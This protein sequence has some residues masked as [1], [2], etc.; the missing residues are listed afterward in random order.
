MRRKFIIFVLVPVLAAFIVTYLFIDR[1]VEHGLESMGERIV[2]AKVEIDNVTLSLSP[3]A[4]QFSRLQVAN[5]RDP[6]SNIFETGRVRF[7]L[8]M[9][10]LLRTKFIVETIEVNDLVLGT[11]RISDGSLGVQKQ[12]QAISSSAG[13]AVETPSLTSEAET[14]R[15]S[16]ELKPPVLDLVR[17]KRELNLDSLLH[18]RNFQTFRLLDSLKSG[19]A[20]S[21]AAWEKSKLE[22][23]NSKR[24]LADAETRIKTIQMNEIKSVDA[25]R[26]ALDKIITAER[27]IDDASKILQNQ[28]AVLADMLGRLSASVQRVDDVAKGDFQNLLRFAQVPDANMKGLT[29]LVLGKE[30]LRK[31]E[32]YLYWVDFARTE[33]PRYTPKPAMATPRRFEGQDIPFPEERTYPKFWIQKISISGGTDKAQDPEYF[34]AG[35]EV[36]DITN[37][38]HQVGKPLTIALSGTKVG[39][40]S[41]HFDA[42][43]DRRTERSL[44]LYDA[45]LTGVPVKDVSTGSPDFLPSRISQA[46]ADI[47]VHAHVPGNSFDSNVQAS[48][49]NMSFVFEQQPRNDVERIVKEV[50]ASVK[51]LTVNLRFWKNS[52]KFDVSFTTNL[53]ELV[54]AQAKRV[55]GNEIARIQDDL[56]TRFYAAVTGERAVVESLLRDR[57]EETA[58][59]LKPYEEVFR[60]TMASVADKK[61]ELESRVEEEKKKP[62]E[63]VKKKVEETVKKLFKKN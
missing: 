6:W 48:L 18:A 4:I 23:E 25:T 16:K 17:I 28:K 35:G 57:N 20:N 62:T 19:I 52:D 63:G 39:G 60:S 5:P 8:N 42:S 1:W 21:G 11:K 12:Q 41:F 3:L 59:Q 24:Q 33:I 51:K 50:L 26:V 44:D 22:L 7:A 54:A 2:G 34:Y 47:S 55:L 49:G 53:D 37:D 58:K 10:Q 29:E 46:I 13:T 43:F 31:M 61:K 38:Q 27:T 9:N 30:G 40:A 45:R 56:R 32:Q 36:R 14:L 15:V